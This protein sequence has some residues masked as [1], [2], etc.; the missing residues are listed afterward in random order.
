M[1]VKAEVAGEFAAPTMEIGGRGE[2]DGS[3]K[4]LRRRSGY[5]RW[6]R[7]CHG[8][9]VG[10]GCAQEGMLEVSTRRHSLGISASAKGCAPSDVIHA[11]S[12]GAFQFSFGKTAPPKE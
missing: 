6:S 4:F 12:L 9:H 5:R 8:L 3:P 2:V 10:S 11:A 1:V 7:D